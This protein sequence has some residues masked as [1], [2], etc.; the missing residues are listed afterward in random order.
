MQNYRPQTYG[1]RIT[2]FQASETL[3]NLSQIDSESM[4]NWKNLSKLSTKPLELHIVPGNHYTMLIEPHI[5]ILAEELQRCL[6]Q[7]QT[8]DK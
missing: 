4:F 3:N 7:A 2:L 8:N 6:N 1:D 5:Q